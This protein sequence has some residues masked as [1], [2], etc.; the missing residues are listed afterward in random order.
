MK[1]NNARLTAVQGLLLTTETYSRP[2]FPGN[3]VISRLRALGGSVESEI[4]APVP[5]LAKYARN[6]A[7]NFQVYEERLAGGYA[8]A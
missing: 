4:L 6:D 8:N 1:L 5:H 2:G 7:N 3:N